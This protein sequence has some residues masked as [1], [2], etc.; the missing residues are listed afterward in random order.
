MTLTQTINTEQN[1]TQRYTTTIYNPYTQNTTQKQETKNKEEEKENKK[2]LQ[3]IISTILLTIHLAALTP[4]PIKAEQLNLYITT[5]RKTTYQTQIIN[6]DTITIPNPEIDTT[7]NG[8]AILNIKD[9]TNN[10]IY[11][12]TTQINQGTTSI[13]IPPQYTIQEKQEQPTITI[14]KNNEIKNNTNTTL[15]TIL[16]DIIEKII[17][18]QQADIYYNTEITQYIQTIYYPD[19]PNLEYYVTIYGLSPNESKNSNSH[20]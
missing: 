16:Y 4:N 3:K 8:K 15:E 19:K 20:P 7:I 18:Q 11:T 9:T 13:Y 5:P 14:T 12:D 2:T 17:H 10:T 6:Q 1:N